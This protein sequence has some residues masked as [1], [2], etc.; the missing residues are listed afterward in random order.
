MDKKWAPA[1]GGPAKTV[2]CDQYETVWGNV[3]HEDRECN[4][5]EDCS[6]IVANGNCFRDALNNEAAKMPRYLFKPC[7]DPRAGE[8]P[9]PPG[10]FKA[11]CH[12]GCC[13]IVE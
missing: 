12:R 2:E 11:R 1:V 6:P 5:D 7:G 8:C 13:A 3:R 10:G 4:S 9:A